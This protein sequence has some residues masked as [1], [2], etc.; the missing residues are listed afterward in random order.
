VTCDSQRLT[1]LR[2]WRSAAAWECT[3][4]RSLTQK[5]RSAS[6][7]SAQMVFYF[8]LV[9]SKSFLKPTDGNE[10]KSGSW[11]GNLN[12]WMGGLQGCKGLWGWCAG[13][14]YSPLVANLSWAPG[15][16]ELNKS[17]E[18]C[19]HLRVYPNSSNGAL[20]FDRECKNRFI[21]G[22]QVFHH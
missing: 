2:T 1:G 3:L 16:P 20:L 6:A 8:I 22:C 11:R 7:N 10:I 9:N 12:Y 13:A 17:N 14:D 4:S 19:M 15:Q 21:L 18:N 5:I